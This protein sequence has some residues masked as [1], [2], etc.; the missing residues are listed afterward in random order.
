MYFL[1]ADHQSS[2][3]WA[4]TLCKVLYILRDWVLGYDE[5]LLCLRLKYKM[6]K[7]RLEIYQNP[8]I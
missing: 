6:G 8:L 5:H 1:E 3:Y 7:L 2:D 4:M